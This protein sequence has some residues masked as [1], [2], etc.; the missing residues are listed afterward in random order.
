MINIECDRI[1]DETAQFTVKCN[2]LDLPPTIG[3]PLPGSLAGLRI[4][5]TWIMT[6][7]ANEISWAHH[8]KVIREYCGLKYN[9]S[10]AIMGT[11]HWEVPQIARRRGSHTDFMR[12]SKLMH[13]WLPVMQMHGHTTGVTVCP[14]CGD[15]CEMVD[16]M[17]LCPNP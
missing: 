14:G 6:N 17:L 3:N 10:N 1:A 16:H 5:S 9:W 12:S 4:E 7:L 11:I 8:S 2:G 15:P 13:G